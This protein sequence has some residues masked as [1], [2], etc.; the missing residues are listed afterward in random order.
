[1][2]GWR[3]FFR[4]S[5]SRWNRS[6]AR[7]LAA[8]EGTIILMATGWLVGRWRAR[9]T[10][11][12]P[13]PPSRFSI[14]YSEPVVGY[15]R[16]WATHSSQ[17][18]EITSSSGR[19]LTARSG[20]AS[21]PQPRHWILGRPS[22]WVSSTRITKALSPALMASPS[23][24][25]TPSTRV[26]LT[27]VP[28]VLPRS[29]RKQTGGLNSIRKWFRERNPSSGTGNWTC[30]DRP[31]TNVSWRSKVY[32]IPEWGPAVTRRTTFIPGSGSDDRRRG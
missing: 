14:R 18:Q 7:S 3:R 10:S 28:L 21:L 23:R 11:P 25:R 12:I 22:Q 8:I 20:G 26:P 29:L 5:S 30:D 24:S 13:P 17:S 31:T 32:S 4:T 2:L 1:M 9:K 15:W 19:A 6:L 27:F 16:R